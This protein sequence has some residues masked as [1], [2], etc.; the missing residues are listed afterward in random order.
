MREG[1]G[2]RFPFRPT[3]PFSD[4]EGVV[5]FECGK[6]NIRLTWL[7]PEAI[8]RIGPFPT[9]G[10]AETFLPRVWSACVD[11]NNVLARG[12]TPDQ[13]GGA[14][15]S[16][17]RSITSCQQR[18]QSLTDEMATWMADMTNRPCTESASKVDPPLSALYSVGNR[19]EGG[20][21]GDAYC[22]DHS[23]DSVTGSS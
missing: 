10:D 8:L 19:T 4:V 3:R 11:G 18:A 9:H 15:H 7:P 23:E 21:W 20:L 14:L 5:G 6:L 13:R 12:S 16:R 17:A 2:L 22:G 1:Y